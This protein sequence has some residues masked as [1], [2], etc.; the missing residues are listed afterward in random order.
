[1][2]QLITSILILIILTPSVFAYKV[3]AWL[4]NW[5]TKE[6][7]QS[8]ENNVDVI[9]TI[10]PFWYNVAE[11]GTLILKKGS[12]DQKIIDLANK[13][14]VLLVPT[15]TNSFKG[16]TVS[17]IF[18]DVDLKKKNIK[19][20]LD[21]VLGKGYDGIDIDY[22]GIHSEDKDVFT[23]YIKDLSLALHSKGKKLTVA[24]QPKSFSTFLKF[25]DRG[26]DWVAIQK[27][28]DEFRIMAYDY[29]WRGSIPRPVAPYYWVEDVIKYAVTK[30][31]KEK[32]YL[33]VPFYGYGWSD[34]FFSTYTYA[35]I[36]LILSKYGVNFQY[37]PLQKT[38]RL[39]YV[40]EFDTRDPKV[41]HEVWFENH[42][43]LD[44]KIDL[45]KKYNL[46]GIAIWRLGKEDKA[47]WQ[48]IRKNLL[49]EPLGDPLYFKDVNH[50]TK[51]SNEITR[52]AYLGIVSGQGDSFE[53]KP[54][55]K[56]NRAEML[57]MALNS[58]ANDTSK[59]AFKETRAEDYIN[60]FKDVN[61]DAWYFA[62]IQ[63][64]VD[65]GIIKGY[66]DGTFKPGQAV[67][68]AEAL[69]IALKSAHINIRESAPGER[70]YEPYMWWAF[71]NGVFDVAT[72]KPGEEL[73][74][75]EA[76]YLLEKIISILEEKV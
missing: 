35:T 15:I 23:A 54:F 4:P 46:A 48:S 61:E 34:K 12:E 20:I 59:Y 24:I 1:M 22:E 47:N 60:P 11:D 68:R 17:P 21:K 56:V 9:N 31:P 67:T 69:K 75:G 13:Q 32:I 7:Y 73:T 65:M 66:G 63:T 14:K 64:A 49:G 8:F 51:Y 74:R 37:D 25:G 18:N 45:V 38:N 44:A 28:V 58:F 6:A 53:Y 43:S 70:W 72:F 50:S 62:Y 26:Q 57:K 71:D 52:L 30:V 19:I 39:F 76:A 16:D 29:G 27:Y 5:D 41:P 10:S 42:V 2:K 33:G 36:E 3:S 55:A 40:S